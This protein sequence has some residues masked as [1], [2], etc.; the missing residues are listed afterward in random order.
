[1]SIKRRTFLRTAGIP[2]VGLLA[3]PKVFSGIF[4]NLE[5]DTAE[6][7]KVHIVFKTHLDVGF[8]N[9]ADKVFDTYIHDFIPRAISLSEEMR[10]TRETEQYGWTTGSFLIYHFLEKSDPAMRKCMETAIQNGDM[11]WHEL[12]FTPCQHFARR[13]AA[14]QV[15]D[16]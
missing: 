7:E 1:M 10:K 16:S 13:S 4:T 15:A 6:I 11:T 8:T 12:P 5:T 3:A 2:T 9:L 14:F